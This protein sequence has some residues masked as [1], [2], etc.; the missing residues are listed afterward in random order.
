M[1]EIATHISYIHRFFKKMR[2]TDHQVPNAFLIGTIPYGQ[3]R[4][5]SIGEATLQG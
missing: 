3:G 5:S 1:K 4:L 2:L